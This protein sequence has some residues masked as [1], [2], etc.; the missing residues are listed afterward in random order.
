MTF[1]CFQTQAGTEMMSLHHDSRTVTDQDRILKKKESE[2]QMLAYASSS[3]IPWT[4]IIKLQ[5]GYFG[6]NRI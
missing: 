3:G 5:G 6:K 4:H 2:E 1:L